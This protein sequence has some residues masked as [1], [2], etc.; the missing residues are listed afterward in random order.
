VSA[1]G[2]ARSRVFLAVLLGTTAALK[3]ALAWSFPGFLSGDDLEI[4]ATAA[5]HAVGLDYAPWP[6]RSLFHPL[7]LAYPAV[8]AGALA[9]LSSPR[10]MTL[11]AAVPTAAFSTLGVWLAYRIARE[12]DASEA[13]ARAAAFLA[14]AAWVPFAYGGTPY[15]RPISSALLLGAFL[16]IVRGGA[17]PRG[18]AAAGLLA[19]AAFAVRWSEGF[20]VLPLAALA[21]S[22]D[23]RGRAALAVLGGFGAGALLFV[24]AFDALTWGAPFAS[25]RAFLAFMRAPHD[26]FTPRPP[27]WYLGMIL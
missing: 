7:L 15:P 18:A 12:L 16:L 23:R 13:G 22:R 26:A 9:G 5:K 14:A 20:A 27:W 4:V 11:L 6:I 19:A 10:W 8:Q 2:G 25:L 17:G 21:L 1:R 24:G 3:L